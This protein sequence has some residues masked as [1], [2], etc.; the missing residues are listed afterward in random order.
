MKAS[1]WIISN[2]EAEKISYEVDGGGIGCDQVAL[3]IASLAIICIHIAM[4]IPNRNMM[5]NMSLGTLRDTGGEGGSMGTL[6]P[7]AESS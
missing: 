1:I 5:K 4:D 6:K 3:W 7:D 2:T